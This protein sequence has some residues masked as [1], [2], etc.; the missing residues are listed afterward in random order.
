M[1]IHKIYEG[2]GYINMGDAINI[3]DVVEYQ[4][5]RTNKRLTGTIVKVMPSQ[6]GVIY[7]A[8]PQEGKN[9]D[10]DYI[11]VE[12]NAI[13]LI[14]RAKEY[15]SLDLVQDK[16][17]NNYII[18][19][20]ALGADDNKTKVVYKAIKKNGKVYV[21]NLEDFTHNFKEVT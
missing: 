16:K 3:G 7:E 2:Y 12:S 20:I 6:F 19:A 9:S 5:S 18:I 14:K 21:M 10:V 17:G 13:V 4:S 11:A 8:K 1:C 15:K